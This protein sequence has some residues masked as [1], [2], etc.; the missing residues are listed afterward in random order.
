MHGNLI[1]VGYIALTITASAAASA[2]GDPERGERALL[3][4]ISCHSAEPN[5]HKTGPSLAGIWRQ[6]AGTVGGFIRYSEPLKQSQVIWDRD[7]L[8]TWLR[9]PQKLIP[10][11]RMTMNGIEDVQ[12]R[13]DI[14]AYLESLA[15]QHAQSSGS[16]SEDPGS[17]EG[18]MRGTDLPDLK[19]LVPKHQ[20]RSIRYCNDTYFVTTVT[21]ETVPY[22]EFNLRFKTDSSDHGPSKGRPALLPA[23]MQG[24]RAF[25]IFAHP[26]E[27]SALIATDC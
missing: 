12:S 19:R 18:I 2:A 16:E 14:I 1:T 25:I 21:G 23:S 10:G 15:S 9:D 20:V 5:I 6:K 27:I 8:D 3:R 24:D 17:P 11:N 7:T 22:W 26:T 4:C 13:Q